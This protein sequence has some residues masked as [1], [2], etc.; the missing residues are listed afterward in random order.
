[1]VDM[2]PGA[3]GFLRQKFIDDQ[4]IAASYEPGTGPVAQ[5]QQ[6]AFMARYGVSVEA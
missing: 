4:L 1:M 6:D 2:A 5:A 3:S